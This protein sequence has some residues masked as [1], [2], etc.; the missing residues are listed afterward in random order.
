MPTVLTIK[1]RTMFEIVNFVSISGIVGAFGIVANIVNSIVFYKQGFKNTVNIGFF[2]LAISDTTCLVTLL[3]ASISMN[4]LLSSLGI[5]WFAMDVMYLSAAWPHICFSRITAFITVYV[6][7]ERY[8][9]I[10]LPLKVKQLITQRIATSTICLIYFV[11]LTTLVPEYATSYLGWRFVLERNDTLVGIIFTSS[12][13]RVEGVVFVLH[14]ILGMASF[15]GVVVF[16][17]LL[18]VKLGQSSKWRNELTPC[19]SK[20]TAISNRDKRTVKMVVLIASVLIV[21]YAPGAVIS[22]TTFIVGPEFNI[23]GKFVNICE[24]TWSI[25]LTFQSINSSVNIF[26]YYSMSSKYKQTLRES[27]SRCNKSMREHLSAKEHERACLA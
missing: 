16:T 27:I 19:H 17:T 20:Q 6:T 1:E 18:V 26:I 25:A 13:K 12:R 7:A 11:N 22:L 9:S 2:G 24:A 15:V 5:P 10:A 23:R 21:C 3:W 14:F 8:L 4:P